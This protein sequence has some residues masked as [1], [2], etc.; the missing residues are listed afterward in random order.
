MVLSGRYEKLSNQVHFFKTASKCFWTK[1]VFIITLNIDLV[2]IF[3][4]R[5]SFSFELVK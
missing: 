5:T 1:S 3:F 2:S 4:L